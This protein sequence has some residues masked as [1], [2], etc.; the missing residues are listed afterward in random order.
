MNLF[1]VTGML[2]SRHFVILMLFLGMANAYIM[3]TNMSVAIVAMVDQKA[4]NGENNTS[5]NECLDQNAEVPIDDD[6][7]VSKYIY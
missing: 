5:S 3:R 2:G 1:S 4:I 6:D 7:D